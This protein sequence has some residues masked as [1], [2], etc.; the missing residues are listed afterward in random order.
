M[1]VVRPVTRFGPGEE[2][3][4]Q[5]AEGSLEVEDCAGFAD[6]GFGECA[7]FFVRFLTGGDVGKEEK[8]NLRHVRIRGLGLLLGGSRLFC[9]SKWEGSR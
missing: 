8:E 7:V 9:C 4:F 6:L 2:P 1:F 3:L 5:D